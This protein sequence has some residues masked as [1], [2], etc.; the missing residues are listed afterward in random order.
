MLFFFSLDVHMTLLTYSISSW[1]YH[2]KLT[3][4]PFTCHLPWISLFVSTVPDCCLICRGFVSFSQFPYKLRKKSV[5]WAIVPLMKFMRTHSWEKGKRCLLLLIFSYY[6]S[7][8]V[9]KHNECRIKKIIH[10]P[11]CTLYGNLITIF[12]KK[13]VHVGTCACIVHRKI[14]LQST[15]HNTTLTYCFISIV[16]S[17]VFYFYLSLFGIVNTYLIH[18]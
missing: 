14:I 10:L 1:L 5:V 13:W 17:I 9:L 3:K 4:W 6:I 7:H 11:T 2:K 15:K 8:Q 18:L 16:F 12:P